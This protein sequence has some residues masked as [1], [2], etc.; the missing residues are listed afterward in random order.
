MNADPKEIQKFSEIAHQWWDPKGLF[1]LL[2]DLNPVRLAW[3]RQHIALR[4]QTVLDVGCG[5]GILT[6]SMAHCGTAY[7]KGIDLAEKSLAIAR[8]HQIES[9]AQVEYQLVAVEQLALDEPQKYDVVT[10]MEML[11][12]VPNPSSIVEAC[13]KLVKPGG[14]VFFST[15]S[16]TPQCYA[17]A[18]LAAEYLTGLLPRG[19]HDYAK[20][21]RPSE[22]A[23]FV[24]HAGL[25]VV[26]L[27]GM[28]YNPITTTFKLNKN[29]SANYLMA[30][31][32]PIN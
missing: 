5:G 3:I 4:G 9:G 8:I 12:H 1:K 18:I 23:S 21:I 2:H 25:E 19:T 26:D 29:V 22:L 13:A 31:R 10:C 32:K 15:L 14:F 17:L 30:A 7:A 11:E 28:M 27:T 6:E 16:R 20:L 24:R